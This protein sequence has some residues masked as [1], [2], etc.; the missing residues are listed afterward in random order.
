M[1]DVVTL[2]ALG[3]ACHHWSRMRHAVT[4]LAS[5]NCFVFVFVT[6][7]AGNGFMFCSC[8]AVQFGSLLVAGST[9]FVGCVG[10]IGDSCR[11]MGL[12][13]AFAVGCTHIGTVRLVALCTKRNLAMNIMAETAC[14]LGVFAW[15]LLQLNN[16]R[17]VAGKTFFS[18]VVGQLDDLG[19]MGIVVAAQTVSELVV[20]FAGVALAALGNVVLDR[21]AMAGMTVLT[22]YAGFV[23]TAIR[24]NI[25]RRIRVTL[26]TIA[27]EQ[28]RLRRVCRNGYQRRHTR[29]HGCH[30]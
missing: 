30:T 9:H 23:R 13:A 17:A 18:N 4:A 1:G 6:G 20:R 25:S 2:A 28:C 8:L 10:C 24:S 16:L 15:C 5:R 26:D 27:A 22:G 11:H 7:Y 3:E 21:R 14:Q 12:M 19:R 29:Q